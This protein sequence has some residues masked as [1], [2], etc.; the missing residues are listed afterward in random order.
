M[1]LAVVR[2]ACA[3]TAVT[4]ALRGDADVLPGARSFTAGCMHA[5]LAAVPL[6]QARVRHVARRVEARLTRHTP[7]RAQ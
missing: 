4:A 1:T 2:R 6:W 7:P 5:E 3:L